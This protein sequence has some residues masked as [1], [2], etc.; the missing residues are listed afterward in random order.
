M[1]KE[2]TAPLDDISDKVDALHVRSDTSLTPDTDV[3][4]RKQQATPE[5]IE[6]SVSKKDRV[7]EP[8]RASKTV[9]VIGG[10]DDAQVVDPQTPSTFGRNQEDY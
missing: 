7:A 10:D 5:D 2:L 4:K 1:S 3:R 9:I 8:P 6:T